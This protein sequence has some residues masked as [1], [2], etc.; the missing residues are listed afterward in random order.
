MSSPSKCWNLSEK[1]RSIN[2]SNLSERGESIKHWNLKTKLGIN[3]N[4]EIWVLITKSFKMLYFEW[5]VG[6]QSKSWHLSAIRWELIKML[7]FECQMS[8]RSKCWNLSEKGGSIKCWYSI[9]KVEIDQII[10]IWLKNKELIR[11]LKFEDNVKNQSK[12]WNLSANHQI[13]QNDVLWVK[14]G[15]SIKKL[16]FVCNKVEI[17]HNVEIWVQNVKSIKML[18]FERKR[19]VRSNVDILLQKW[20][21]I[22][23]LEFDWKIRNWSEC[24]NLR[25][26]LRIDQNVEIWVQNVKSIKMLKFEWKRKF[27]QNVQI[28]VKGG[29]P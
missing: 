7:K 19:G 18:K 16:T 13:V 12:C 21:S 20:K 4:A 15:E 17:D 10:G 8:N 29:N 28:W 6:N 23:L 9:A 14:S 1:G 2:M 24:W 26:T 22:K 11:I 5:K 3:Q 25:T 27:D